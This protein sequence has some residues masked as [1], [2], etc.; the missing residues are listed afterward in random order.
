MGPS[1]ENE[2]ARLPGD[3]VKIFFEL[4]GMAVPFQFVI[5]ANRKRK[6]GFLCAGIF[7]HREE[8]VWP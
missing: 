2:F 8:R 6:D 4:S 7:S 1:F 3:Q 5:S